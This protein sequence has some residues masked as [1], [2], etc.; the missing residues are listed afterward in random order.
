ME[1]PVTLGAE[2]TAPARVPDDHRI[3]DLERLVD[4]GDFALLSLDV[5]DTYVYRE[6][7]RPIDVFF[8]LAQ[9]LREKGM[10][11]PSSSAASFVRER[12]QAEG[13]ARRKVAGHEVTLAQIWAEFPAGYLRAGSVDDAAREEFA[14]EQ[15]VVRVYE[16]MRALV[17]RARERGMKVAFVSDTY[18]SRRQIHQLAGLEPD[19]TIVSCEHGTSKF[20]G[21]HRVLLRKSRIDAARVLHV[22][23]S[24]EADVDG[25]EPLG[26]ARYWF[27][28]FPAGF[29]D[30]PARE[31]PDALSA[32][33]PYVSEP[34]DGL[35]SCRSHAMSACTDD[36]ARWGAGVLGPV[37]AGYA[38]WVAARCAE[39][40]IGT[41]FC[42]MREGR[43]LR[44]ALALTGAPLTAHEVYVS[45]FV[46]LKAAILHGSVAELAR[47]V[48]R[49][50]PV[51][52]GRVLAQLG[53]APA[54]VPGLE[55]ASILT[56]AETR[57]L[58]TRIAGEPRLRAKVL[59]DSAAARRG[60]LAHLKPLLPGRG[61]GV[62][63][64]DLGY[65]GTIQM[66]LQS[67]L[68]HERFAVRTHGLYLVT[69]GDVHETQ[70]TGAAVEGWI[71]ENGQPIAMA[72]TFMR[73]PEVFEQSLMA[74]CGTTLGHD[75]DG[76]PRLD[77]WL[78]PAEQRAEIAAVQRGLDAFLRTWAAHRAARG[79]APA[80]DLRA[81]ARAIAVRAVARPLPAE[82]ALFA[83]WR[84]DENFGSE[85]VRTL[86]EPVGLHD[87]E[88]TH[89]SA[90]QLASLPSAQLYWPFAYA[91]GVG[92]PLGEAVAAI[93]LR[94]TEP[95]AFEAASGAEPMTFAWDD[96]G[97]FRES[98]THGTEYACNSEGRCWYRASLTVASTPPRRL[99]F[100][101]GAPGD[102]LRLT[103]VRVH[104]RGEDG[105]HETRTFA[106][107]A[108]SVVGTRELVPGLHE[109][110]AQ[111]M[112]IAVD[113][114]DIAG[115]HGTLDADLFFARVPRA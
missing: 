113:L 90:H 56:P 67:V 68:D 50:S 44:H 26:V 112:V 108:L 55:P 2:V 82:L 106:S 69:G 92:E 114:P 87:W 28:K 70:A 74:D 11:Y 80:H 57:A 25:P 73:S 24:R 76:T 81:Y 19:W 54:D 47:F 8:L 86:A 13:R 3:A 10:L 88:R 6:V 42:L 53:L 31:L 103:G 99:A 45:R 66:G 65:K 46:A 52:A 38:D 58:V 23:D 104:W 102:W 17:A 36:H 98:T 109:V 49:P 5:F 7:P 71:A 22:G 12:A 72:H 105:A 30:L 9:V 27:R 39:L 89:L 4:S 85:S 107:D 37:V 33:A 34:D 29:D 101:F 61:R 43:A 97:G 35:T 95:W 78:V 48:L 115:F 15:R 32:R 1:G 84:H 93:F 96:G 14:C 62:A 20:A 94:A 79:D 40:G 110:G 21:L 16:P 111:P 59:A 63:I 18:F 60:L 77:E 75:E 83:H 91:R 41:V 51:R 100:A 64:V